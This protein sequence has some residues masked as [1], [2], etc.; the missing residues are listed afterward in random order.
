V[1]ARKAKGR[2]QNDTCGHDPSSRTAMRALCLGIC[3]SFVTSTHA[4]VSSRAMRKGTGRQFRSGGVRF[5]RSLTAVALVGLLFAV[6]QARAVTFTVDSTAS[7]PDAVQGDGICDD[8]TGACTLSAAVGEAASVP[9]CQEPVAIH[10]SVSG[11]I[12]A[13]IEYHFSGGSPCASPSLS[14]IGPGADSLILSGGVSASGY[15]SQPWASCPPTCQVNAVIALQGLHVSG[16]LHFND[17]T[18][19]LT[20]V[21][22]DG[23]IEAGRTSLS[24]TGSSVDSVSNSGVGPLPHP[25][26]DITVTDST[27]RGISSYNTGMVLLARVRVSGGL[28]VTA[29]RGLPAGANV[30]D[31]LIEESP[32]VGVSVAGGVGLV[33]STIRNNHGAGVVALYNAAAFPNI[34]IVDSTISGNSGI[35]VA[36]GYGGRMSIVRSTIAR[37]RGGGIGTSPPGASMSIGDSIIADNTD[38]AGE[39]LDCAGEANPGSTTA[40][41][42]LIGSTGGCSITHDGNLIGVDPRLGP[43]ADNGGLTPTH[44]L[45]A[46]S[47]AVDAAGACTGTDQRGVPRPQGAACDIGAFEFACGNSVIDPGEECDG[48]AGNC[49]AGTTCDAVCNCTVRCGDGVKADS[50]ACDDGNTDDCDGCSSTCT[51]VDAVC[52]DGITECDEEADDGNVESCDG[53]SAVCQIE[54]CGNGVTECSEECDSG[55]GGGAFVGG[56]CGFCTVACT[57]Q[58][59]TTTTVPSTTTTT[60][61]VQSPLTTTTAP[62]T[63]S[64][65]IPA[66]T[67][68]TTAPSTTSTT[69]AASIT[70]TTAPNPTSST[71]VLSPTTTTTAPSTTSTT[72]PASPTTSTSVP[73]TTST[74][75]PMC[76]A[77]DCDGNLCTVG[78][79]C[80][81]GVCHPGTPVT[82][83]RLSEFVFVR[84]GAAARTCVETGNKAKKWGQVGTPLA[85][86]SRL[87]SQANTVSGT[88]LRKKVSQARA[89]V[90]LARRRLSQE[91]PQLSPTCAAAF[92]Q[93]VATATTALACIP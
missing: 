16:P 59:P 2:S 47:P 60:T 61:T 29:D 84:R 31:S 9:T 75:L 71:T 54:S 65:T 70:T 7:T 48:A 18:V 20:D 42:S 25:Y 5:R 27:T 57:C 46:G 62:S 6:S 85:K 52:G 33:R 89:A 35:G 8:G 19:S 15:P 53:V 72:T 23:P 83:G 32:G 14:I 50:E 21:I 77:D 4:A 64:T 26:G 73:S 44:A 43:L 39:A 86:A 1:V 69:T 78:D 10:F 45:L 66:T 34:S 82:P 80:D 11:Q 49:P 91:G 38:A 76:K 37:N 67:T 81:S 74:T 17:A 41:R 3:L 24:I 63:T 93:A 88:K 13:G 92:D 79:T 22:A 36:T 56:A 55:A 40:I 28:S 30:A 90:K 68:T 58:P 87:L 12:D 51:R